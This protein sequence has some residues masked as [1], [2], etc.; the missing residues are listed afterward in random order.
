MVTPNIYLIYF[1]AFS[2]S[3]LC[4]EIHQFIVLRLL[5]SPFT[6]QGGLRPP[7]TAHAW[8]R[9]TCERLVNNLAAKNAKDANVVRSVKGLFCAIRGLNCLLKLRITQRLIRAAHRIITVGGAHPTVLMV[10]YPQ[11][12]ISEALLATGNQICNA[13]T[14]SQP[15]TITGYQSYI[16]ALR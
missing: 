16:S 15:I 7:S 8:W 13:K 6:S 10:E 14:L 9:S 2:S 3:H 4:V 12:S 5:S 11:A 1:A